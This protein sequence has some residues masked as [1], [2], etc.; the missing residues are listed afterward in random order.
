MIR[1]QSEHDAVGAALAAYEAALDRY[2]DLSIGG[3]D[4]YAVQE[5]LADVDNIKELLDATRE[6]HDAHRRELIELPAPPAETEWLRHVT[7][8]W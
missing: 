1:K 5:A 3:A 2:D 8:E 4:E 6:T 7:L